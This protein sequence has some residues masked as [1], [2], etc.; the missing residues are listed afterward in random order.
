MTRESGYYP[1]GA[2][3]D[4]NAP[5]NQKDPPPCPRCDGTGVE[6]DPT[7]EDPEDREFRCWY[8][9]GTGFAEAEP[10]EREWDE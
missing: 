3:F 9:D 2:E 7:A 8:C 1:P 6:L 4:P 5:W 10:D